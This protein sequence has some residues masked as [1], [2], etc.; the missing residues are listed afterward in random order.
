M[1]SR[2]KIGIVTFVI[3]TIINAFINHKEL[4]RGYK[5]VRGDYLI[6]SSVVID[7]SMGSYITYKLK[8]QGIDSLYTYRL[9][10]SEIAPDIGDEID[11]VIIENQLYDAYLF[12]VLPY[13]SFITLVILFFATSINHFIDRK[14]GIT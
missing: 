6:Y 8:V 1:S 11:I 3:G 13:F 5:Y 10:L 12:A 14:K 9:Q 2:V 7:K 4:V